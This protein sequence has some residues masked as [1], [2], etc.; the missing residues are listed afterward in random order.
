[1]GMATASTV[2]SIID[3]LN[4]IY[5]SNKYIIVGNI[6]NLR[7]DK[8]QQHRS[9]INHPRSDLP[10]Y[11][12]DTSVTVLNLQPNDVL[13]FNVSNCKSMNVKNIFYISASAGFDN[14]QG[15]VRL[16]KTP[17]DNTE[18]T[19][20][21]LNIWTLIT[22]IS[23][24]LFFSTELSDLYYDDYGKKELKS[25][26]E[27]NKLMNDSLFIF[28]E[29]SYN[30]IY[31]V[32]N[33]F[34]NIHLTGGNKNSN[35]LLTSSEYHLALRL[36]G[37]FKLSHESLSLS[38]SKK[39]P[40][41]AYSV[42][43]ISDD[44]L[45]SEYQDISK[46]HKDILEC[47]SFFKDY[48]ITS[49]AEKSEIR[50]DN[51]TRR[52][53]NEPN[54]EEHLRRYRVNQ[55]FNVPLPHHLRKFKPSYSTLAT[56]NS[57][58]NCS[59]QKLCNNL[60]T[61]I[62]TPSI[63]YPIPKCIQN[64]P[65]NNNITHLSN[66]TSLVNNLTVTN[67]YFK[68]IK[69]IILTNIDNLEKGQLEIEQLW[70]NMEKIFVTDQSLL[71]ISNKVVLNHCNE[72]L[73]L[74]YQKGILK[75]KFPTL[76]TY[77]NDISN[78]YIT[79]SIICSNYK[80]LSHINICVTVSQNI[81]Y[82]I[83]KYKLKHRT[84]YKDISYTD[85]KNSILLPDKI[86]LGWYFISLFCLDD[87]PYGPIF[88]LRTRDTDKYLSLEHRPNYLLLNENY[89]EWMMENRT[90]DPKNLPM[91]SPP[92]AWSDSE[93][94]GYLENRLI[95]EEIITGSALYHDHKIIN[96][97]KLY[98][99]V[100]YLNSIKFNINRDLLEYLNNTEDGKILLETGNETENLD[101]YYLLTLAESY[102][103]CSFY[104]TTNAD[105]R[106]RIYTQ[107]FY[108]TYQGS[109]INTALLEYSEGQYLTKD[110][111]TSLYIYGASLYGLDKLNFEKRINWVLDNMEKIITMNIDFILKASS[112]FTFASF[113]L[114]LKQISQNSKTI[115]KIPVFL[116][117]TC[118]G[119]QHI[120][121][122]IQDIDLAK[123]VNLLY[124]DKDD[125][126]KDFYGKMI[127]I[128]NNSLHDLGHTKLGFEIFKQIHLTRSD[129]KQAIM[130][131][132]YN[133]SLFGMK[134][135]IGNQLGVEITEKILKDN[136]GTIKKHFDYKGKDNNGNIILLSE[137][138]LFEIA[139]TVR[140][141]IFSK[142]PVLKEVYDYFKS[143]TKLL[144]NLKLP[145]IWFTPTGTTLIQRYKKAKSQKIT[146]NNWNKVTSI[147]YVQYVD[148]TNKTKQ[149]NAIIP[150]IIHSLDASHL[151]CIIEEA[152]RIGLKNVLSIHDCFG[153]HPNDLFKLNE[154]VRE[155]FIL[156]YSNSSFLKT[157][158]NR[159][160]QTI[161]DN[162][163]KII[164]KPVVKGE[165][166]KY[167]VVSEN[168]D[169]YYEIPVLPK[170][171]KLNLELIR[172]S[173]YM[174]S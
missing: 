60:S 120:S 72:Q 130:T 65:A 91:I 6:S 98:L 15:V 94:G 143:V 30:Y 118:N 74:S 126:I 170:K 36:R 161:K 38:P 5:V 148:E 25:R 79:Y 122:I 173:K 131:L 29:L 81:I 96:R 84:D 111:L 12:M 153:T 92:L 165:P 121:A 152:N 116:D 70:F 69:D 156:L 9:L 33:K 137:K 157:F 32:F 128:I 134:E 43:S 63:I 39:L 166:V 49:D 109:D 172:K 40:R 171:G 44:T 4:G 167:L 88:E 89:K 16:A 31:H 108:L 125:Q 68:S 7:I 103:S 80:H 35:H 115:V 114:V 77:L 57:M 100:N 141:V 144:V 102:K 105:W 106:G 51:M 21:S 138:H 110:G 86:Q 28:S 132:N 8:R 139:K 145:I 10:V 162:N 46:N 71:R 99:A 85:F 90:I 95:K 168:S 53:K 3:K 154:L 163:L 26:I 151:M 11:A 14:N 112:P 75:R 127:P 61:T 55:N 45:F 66:N 62:S 37:M 142:H 135:Q 124:D 155:N 78:I 13:P 54:Y 22:H 140:K 48:Y 87:L 47:V 27:L 42:V 24:A 64:N 82:H 73:N 50:W 93:Y 159:L 160:L 150:N 59:D 101:R 113:C 129:L 67:I 52:L 136:G 76:Y 174:I 2:N 158:H 34:S 164:K 97:E 169:Q 146:V 133:V 147:R 18:L 149:V 17:D 20:F 19:V 117:A 83:Y 107:S 104:L 56:S 41:N 58:T 23:N 119:I 1:M 123:E